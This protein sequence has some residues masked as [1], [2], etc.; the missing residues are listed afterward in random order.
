M[1]CVAVLLAL[2]VA[3]PACREEPVEPSLRAR[4]AAPMVALAESVERVEGMADSARY[5]VERGEPMREALALLRGSLDEVRAHAGELAHA[6]VGLRDPQAAAIARQTVDLALQAADRADEEI[7]V[8]APL[9]D[10]DTLM[11]RLVATWAGAA[12]DALVAQVAALPPALGAAPALPEPCRTLWDNRA[13]WA[14]LVADRSRRLAG[15]PEARDGFLAN[16]FGEDRRAADSAERPCW[17]AHGA[18][19]RALA[20]LRPLVERLS[21]LTRLADTPAPQAP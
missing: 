14:A 6:A 5:R 13:R 20:D 12:D 10:A 2:A 16:P 21:E 8:L 7:A 17:R 19:P 15:T 4:L 1:R 9:V 18:L 11:D 3:L